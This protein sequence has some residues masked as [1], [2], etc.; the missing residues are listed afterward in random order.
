M[1]KL[2]KGIKIW[3][4]PGINFHALFLI[5]N[6]LAKIAINKRFTYKDSTKIKELLST[7][8]DAMIFQ[9]F[10]SEHWVALTKQWHCDDRK[11]Y[12]VESWPPAFLLMNHELV[13]MGQHQEFQ[14]PF[15]IPHAPIQTDHEYLLFLTLK[16]LLFLFKYKLAY[17]SNFRVEQGLDL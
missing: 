8:L 16:K 7:S 10:V 11:F 3:Y 1:Q 14:F 5:N 13:S 6:T 15:G 17:L 4:T 12:W 2:P 9:L